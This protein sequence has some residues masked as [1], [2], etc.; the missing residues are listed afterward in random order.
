M[1]GD[2]VSIRPLDELPERDQPGAY[3]DRFLDWF[4][5][6]ERPYA[7][8]EPRNLRSHKDGS[9]VTRKVYAAMRQAVYRRGL[10]DQVKV[11]MRRG[12]ALLER[13]G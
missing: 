8:V 4:L 3:A 5:K 2:V 6:S 9:D 11:R 10:G 7:I 13:I 1:E 12:A